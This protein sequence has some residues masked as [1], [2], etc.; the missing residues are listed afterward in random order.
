[1]PLDM[2]VEKPHSR[3][4][5]LEAQ[6]DMPIRLDQHS[7]PTHRRLRV[8]SRSIADVGPGFFGG[9]VD[10]LEGVAVKVEGVF[11]R[12]VVVEN[13]LDGLVLWED[14]GVRIG[15]VDCDV[16]GGRTG[17]QGGVEGG[18]FG[19]DIGDVIEEGAGEC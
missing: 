4:I 8:L 5:R 12:V 3:I 15:A 1:M 14:E 17:G 2:T 6:H 7:I 16:V 13:E 9:A 19:K 11:A 18:N 10:E